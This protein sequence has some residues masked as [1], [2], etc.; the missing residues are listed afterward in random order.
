MEVFACLFA[1]R[2]EKQDFLKNFVKECIAANMLTDVEKQNVE[3]ILTG[4]NVSIMNDNGNS[5]LSRGGIKLSSHIPYNDLITKDQ[6]IQVAVFTSLLSRYNKTGKP[7]LLIGDPDITSTVAELLEKNATRMELSRSMEMVHSFGEISVCKKADFIRVR[8]TIKRYPINIYPLCLYSISI[9]E[10]LGKM[11]TEDK[12]ATTLLFRPGPI[13]LSILSG[14]PLVL[15]NISQLNDRLLP[16]L[17]GL[18]SNL[19]NDDFV[20]F[21]DTSL[22]LDT[23]IA[24]GMKAIVTSDRKDFNQIERKDI[25]VHVYCQDYSDME[26]SKYEFEDKMKYSLS[27]LK[28]ATLLKPF[29][30]HPEIHAPFYLRYL[31][32]ELSL[33]TDY[34]I[35]AEK[36]DAMKEFLQFLSLPIDVKDEMI[37]EDVMKY[38]TIFKDSILEKIKNSLVTDKH[39]LLPTKTTIQ[40]L[41]S[42]VLADESHTPII[43]EGDPGVGKTAAAENYMIQCNMDY[44]RINF[45]NNSSIDNRFGCYTLVN[46]EFQFKPGSITK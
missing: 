3:V 31:E 26:Y 14:T 19:G 16:R 39:D 44:E 6:S 18:L 27:I 37:I 21:E 45:S 28:K 34:R 36:N 46:G 20:L 43:L 1:E 22:T 5:V 13:L 29:F 7:L 4:K 41:L 11:N 9:E 42:V 32:S 38:N 15:N 40:L 12:D 23:V 2:K 8:N 24:N 35:E 17:Y 25:F 33:R 10:K 30:I